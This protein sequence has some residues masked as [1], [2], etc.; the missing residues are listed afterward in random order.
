M[1]PTM[2][3][4]DVIIIGAGIAGLSTAIALRR[5][6]HHVKVF[7]QSS[8]ADEVGAAIQLPPNAMRI[9]VKWGFLR[10]RARLELC[11][12]ALTARADTLE[13]LYKGSFSDF[14]DK[15]G[16]MWYSSHRVDLHN[17]LK[18]LATQEDASGKPVE[19]HLASKVVDID[20]NAGI[21]TLADGSIHAGGLIVAASGIH[22]TFLSLVLPPGQ[23]IT[24]VST[25]T[26][27]FR[28]LIPTSDLL[29][30]DE[31]APFM[32]EPGIKIFVGQGSKRLVWY[33]CRG[34]EVQNF[35]GIHPDEEQ[36]S[37]GC[38]IL[39]YQYGTYYINE[40]KDTLTEMMGK[41][42]F[43][44]SSSREYLLETYKE[45]SPVLLRVMEKAKI[46]KLWPLLHR[47]PLRSW[48]TG[49]LIFI[50]DA[51]HPMLPHQGQAGAQAIEDACALGLLFEDVGPEDVSAR[52]K[53]YEKVRMGRAG[54]VQVFSRFG[55]DQADRV[56]QEVEMIEGWK[57]VVPANIGEFHDWNFSWD[58]YSECQRVLD[59]ERLEKGNEE[60][61]S[62]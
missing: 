61:K 53:L 43:H 8:F 22:T 2:K 26:S 55:Q 34:G 17:E 59:E 52:L 38:P 19:I 10:D 54:A 1:T 48:H 13:P 31:I 7:E 30:N 47:A 18:L 6:G 46:V 9:L 62:K 12:A 24:P 3:S 41:T 50:G 56:K 44:A 27:A 16:S 57:G 40:T 15:Y 39:R 51:A 11:G 45:F 5:V 32:K 35:V 20:P 28:F 37:E 23:D 36:R 60:D 14:T 33:P 58:V 29:P 21:I 42:D 4:L 49:R 25:G